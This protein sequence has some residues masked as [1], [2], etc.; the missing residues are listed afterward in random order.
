MDLIAIQSVWVQAL[1]LDN[2]CKREE[3]RFV[4]WGFQNLGF[5]FKMAICQRVKL[6]GAEMNNGSPSQFLI[7]A[8]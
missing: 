6:S 5:L 1:N 2:S 4:S 8:V 7:M 3:K